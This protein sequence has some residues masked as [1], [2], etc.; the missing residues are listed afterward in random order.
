LSPSLNIFSCSSS[1]QDLLIFSSLMQINPLNK[2]YHRIN[3]FLTLVMMKR[4]CFG[5]D[6]SHV[7][8]F[9][10]NQRL[11]LLLLSKHKI[12][13]GHH[14]SLKF[15]E[16][17]NFDD[18]ALLFCPQYL[19]KFSPFVKL[20]FPFFFLFLKLLHLQVTLL[21][22]HVFLNHLPSFSSCLNRLHTLFPLKLMLDHFLIL[23][24]QLD[25]LFSYHSFYNKHLM[26][27]QQRYWS[28]PSLG[29]WIS[30]SFIFFPQSISFTLLK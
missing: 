16:S 17:F 22:L 26:S 4:N 1:A 13:H 8:S 9:C 24:I 2:F 15:S 10:R 21:V 11:C 12:V 14:C 3:L 5:W 23:S 6:R 30:L 18:R 29:F 20:F 19:C 25:L 27:W 28:N 7:L